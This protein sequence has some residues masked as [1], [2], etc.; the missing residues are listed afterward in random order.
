MNAIILAAGMGTR[1]RPLTD[2]LPKVLVEVAGESFFARQLRQLR[3]IGA[4]DITVV[5]GYHAEA[6]APWTGEPGLSFVYNDRYADC[7][8]LWSMY[9]VRERLGDT[10]VLDGDL[11]LEEGS[12]PSIP[13][14]RSGWFVGWRENMRNEWV[15]R[16]DE[17]GR[18]RRIDVASGAGWILTG[19]SYWTAADGRLLAPLMEEA[20]SRR[21]WETLFWDEVPRRALEL[22]D[23]RIQRLPFDGW[24]EIDSLEDK[25]AFEARRRGSPRVPSAGGRH[26]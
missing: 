9:L 10:Y 3:A 1:L 16:T 2:A 5:T 8:N 21:G 13:P 4:S 19:L 18:V 12:I 20:V 24:A 7:N 11:R 17:T 25:V 26:A 23:A 15:V 22:F 6:F 14:S